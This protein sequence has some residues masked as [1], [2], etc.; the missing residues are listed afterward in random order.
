MIRRS[1]GFSDNQLLS[2]F[3]YDN[4]MSLPRHRTRLSHSFLGLRE[5]EWVNLAHF[6]LKSL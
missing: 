6:S 3:N 5:S 4:G 2:I 1:V